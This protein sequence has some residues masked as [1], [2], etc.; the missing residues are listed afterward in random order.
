MYVAPPFRIGESWYNSHYSQK[1]GWEVANKAAF[2]ERGSIRGI[3]TC[4][5]KRVNHF[6]GNVV[7]IV[8]VWG[9]SLILK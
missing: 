1:T 8:R 3:L 2:F 6:F 7:V 4:K 5:R 9:S